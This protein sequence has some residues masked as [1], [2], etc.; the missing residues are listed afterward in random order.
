MSLK[1]LEE[2]RTEDYLMTPIMRIIVVLVVLILAM[3][4]AFIIFFHFH[5]NLPKFEEA[6]TANIA[7]NLNHKTS[8]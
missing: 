3:F 8:A 6:A 2:G 1:S 4:V 7:G 5:A